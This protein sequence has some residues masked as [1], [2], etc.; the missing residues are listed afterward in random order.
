MELYTSHC[1]LLGEHKDKDEMES[2]SCNMP[3]T[4]PQRLHEGASTTEGDDHLLTPWHVP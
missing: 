4:D 1:C 3:V 2:Y